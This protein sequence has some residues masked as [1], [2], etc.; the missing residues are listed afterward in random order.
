MNDRLSARI[1]E[2]ESS[3]GQARA[4]ARNQAQRVESELA[5]A[6]Q[7]VFTMRESRDA[8][9]TERDALAKRLAVGVLFQFFCHECLLIFIFIFFFVC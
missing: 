2:L 9:A 3:L 6:L 5:L 4:D 7:E 1:A 8:I